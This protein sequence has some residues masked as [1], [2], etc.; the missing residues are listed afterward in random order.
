MALTVDRRGP[1]KEKCH[2][3]DPKKIKVHK[4]VLSIYIAAKDVLATLH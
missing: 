2:Q 4:S 1:S 3:L